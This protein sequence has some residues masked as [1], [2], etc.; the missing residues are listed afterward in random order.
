MNRHCE[1]HPHPSRAGFFKPVVVL[2]KCLEVAPC[3]YNGAM[4]SDRFVKQLEPHVSFIPICP[5]IEIGLG[6]PRDP[7]RIVSK[8]GAF[9]LFQP[10]TGSDLSE[11]MRHF[12]NQFLTSL[13]EVD[14][15]ILKSRSPSCGIKNVKRFL[16]TD[17]KIPAG[18]GAGF[19]AAEVLE[20][21]PG[22][23]VEDEG[24]LNHPKIRDH[25]LT[26]LFTL[27][28]FREAKNANRPEALVRFHATH[29]L[30]LMAYHQKEIRFLGRIVGNSEK[31]PDGDLFN[32]YEPHL[33]YALAR[34]SRS[35]STINVLMHAFGYFSDEISKNEKAFFLKNL[36]SYRKEG[37]P[38]SAVLSILKGWI[39]RFQNGYL[40]NQTFF[41]PYP[42]SLNVIDIEEE[43]TKVR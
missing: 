35:S 42:E 5:E 31:K 32:E 4:I 30:L 6:V 17:A 40:E 2:S 20:R 29:K 11:K 10:A 3:R 18:K 16:R 36:K 14:G 43:E 21:F 15:F 13:N 37:L 25:F 8:N 33:R 19:F 7:V 34:P 23:A 38:L 39:V 22:L 12:S 26:K 27:A 9:H 1:R 41:D 24:R 28:R